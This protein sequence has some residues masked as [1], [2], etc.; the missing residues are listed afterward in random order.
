[1]NKEKSHT[2]PLGNNGVRRPMGRSRAH[3]HSHARFCALTSVSMCLRM[4]VKFVRSCR[5]DIL[6]RA[7]FTSTF[8]DRPVAKAWDVSWPTLAS[9]MLT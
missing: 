1:M 8:L 4:L 6:Q 5:F 7:C 3:T 2:C 9:S